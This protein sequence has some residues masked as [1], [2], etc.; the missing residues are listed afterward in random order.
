MF[1]QRDGCNIRPCGYLQGLETLTSLQELSL[2]YIGL[3]SLEGLP[4]LP[5][6]RVLHLADNKIQKGLEV[7]TSLKKLEKLN[8]VHNSIESMDELRPLSK[9]SIKQLD[10]FACPVEE[11]NNF[12]EAVFEMLPSLEVLDNANKSGDKNSQGESLYNVIVI[13]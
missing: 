1:V 11:S 13:I 2:C 6:L 7:L 12:R 8:L 5:D 10:L 4:V 9:L 3:T